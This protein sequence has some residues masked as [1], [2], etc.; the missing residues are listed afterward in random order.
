MKGS[1]ISCFFLEGQQRRIYH[2][3]W[4]CTACSEL[5]P[6]LRSGFGL[7]AGENEERMG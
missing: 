2:A 3:N 1:E 6:F 4:I 5:A 7:S